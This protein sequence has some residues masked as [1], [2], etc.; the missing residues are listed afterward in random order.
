MILTLYQDLKAR[1]LAQVPECKTVALWNN[2][3]NNHIGTDN[4]EN[5]WRWPAVFIEFSDIDWDDIGEG[6]QQSDVEITLHQAYKTLKDEDPDLFQF[7][8]KVHVAVNGYT[9]PEFTALN[10]LEETQDVNHDNVIDWQTV[11]KTKVL[12]GTGYRHNDSSE[13]TINT[14]TINVDLDVDNHVI[15]TGDGIP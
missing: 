12:D 10:R 3:I 15:G 11:Y 5:P 2:Q 14:L 7:V 9:E 4:R 1:I 6:V 13:A 8:C